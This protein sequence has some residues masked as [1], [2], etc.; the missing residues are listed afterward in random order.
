MNE[1]KFEIDFFEL[2]FLAE[3]CIPP[4]PI[5][6]AMFFEK[7]SEEFYHKMTDNQRN[8]IFEW[9]KPKLDLS[10]EDCKHFYDRFNPD[11]QYIL[12]IDNF[13]SSGKIMIN[14]YLFND[15]YHISRNRSVIGKYIAKINIS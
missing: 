9:I 6:R 1:N 5:A 14:C 3:A 10:N 2:C 4:V 7:L 13:D 8:K 11:N 15:K 12:E